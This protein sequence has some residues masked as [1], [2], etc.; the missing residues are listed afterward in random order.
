MLFARPHRQE[1]RWISLPECLGAVLG[2]ALATA[3]VV[4]GDPFVAKTGA[5]VFVVGALM[6]LATYRRT[7]VL[8][9]QVRVTCL[10][11]TESRAIEGAT[12]VARWSSWYSIKVRGL[13]L[14]VVPLGTMSAASAIDLARRVGNGLG[15]VRVEIDPAIAQG[16]HLERNNRKIFLIWVLLGVPALICSAFALQYLLF[17]R[18]LP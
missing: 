3:G 4:R 1:V 6:G 5:I 12:I 9:D 8:G 18:L 17:G 11:R 16:A 14:S 13:S 2:I 10:L 7:R 15:A